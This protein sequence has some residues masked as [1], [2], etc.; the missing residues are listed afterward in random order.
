[1]SRGCTNETAVQAESIPQNMF[2]ANPISLFYMVVSI[3][4]LAGIS[5]GGL[6]APNDGT[7]YLGTFASQILSDKETD[8]HKPATLF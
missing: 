7:S 8:E 2:R 3:D 1:M 6:S 4:L 5:Y